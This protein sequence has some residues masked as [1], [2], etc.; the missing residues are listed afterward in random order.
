[1]AVTQLNVFLFFVVL[2]FL[3]F[4]GY[5]FWRAPWA[6]FEADQLSSRNFDVV[7]TRPNASSSSSSGS[8]TTSSSIGS[9]GNNVNKVNDAVKWELRWSGLRGGGYLV[10]FMFSG[11]L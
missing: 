1:M 4:N 2:A 7:Y 5:S 10:C 11:L 9:S 3:G 6:E 8:C